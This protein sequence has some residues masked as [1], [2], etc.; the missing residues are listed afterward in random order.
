[1]SLKNNADF[2]GKVCLVSYPSCTNYHQFMR[3]FI[4][5][6]QRL[7]TLV[8]ERPLNKPECNQCSRHP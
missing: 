2:P 8:W 7:G 5:A 6:H 1:L 3:Y 4:V